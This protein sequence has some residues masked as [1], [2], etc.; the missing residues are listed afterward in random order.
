MP[1]P[2]TRSDLDRHAAADVGRVIPELR[3]VAR[4]PGHTVPGDDGDLD[5][6]G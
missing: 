1:T 3:R 5:Y 6:T 2:H 4:L